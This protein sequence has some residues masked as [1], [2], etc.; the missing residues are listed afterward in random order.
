[1]ALNVELE[2]TRQEAVMVFV[3]VLS[4]HLQESRKLSVRVICL[5]KDQSISWKLDGCV[6]SGG[7]PCGMDVSGTSLVLES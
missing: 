7:Q 5:R 4:R 6:R 1:M 3:K 2:R